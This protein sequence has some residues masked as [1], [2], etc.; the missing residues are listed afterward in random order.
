MR[1]RSQAYQVQ[2]EALWP[3]R[4]GSSDEDLGAVRESL[5]EARRD[6]F[7]LSAISDYRVMRRAGSGDSDRFG[8]GVTHDV[9]QGGEVGDHGV[10]GTGEGIAQQGHIRDQA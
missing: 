8:A 9:W 5:A 7:R 2:N 6:A 3:N 1:F 10:E 4:R